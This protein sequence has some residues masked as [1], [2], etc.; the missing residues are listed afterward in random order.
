MP[1]MLRCIKM[2]LHPRKL[3]FLRM[4]LLVGAHCVTQHLSVVAASSGGIPADQPD[5]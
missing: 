2:H 3:R 4:P 5:H 1:A